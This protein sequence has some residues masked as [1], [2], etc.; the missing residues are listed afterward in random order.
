[1]RAA[2]DTLT[3]GEDENL[4]GYVLRHHQD[5]P[6]LLKNEHHD[7]R[8]RLEMYAGLLLVFTILALVAAYTLLAPAALWQVA[9]AI[10]AYL[11]LAWLAYEACISSALGYGDVLREIDRFVRNQ[12]SP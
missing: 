12:P 9:L 1:M 10:F 2:E 7:Y 3:L 4:E 8:T 5:L 6:D 11:A